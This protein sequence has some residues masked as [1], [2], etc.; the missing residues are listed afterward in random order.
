MAT[1][2][3]LVYV[4]FTKTFK[5]MAIVSYLA[6]YELSSCYHSIG[7]PPISNHQE[8]APLLGGKG[9]VAKD[10]RCRKAAFVWIRPIN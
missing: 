8:V 9:I 3:S 7:F 1:K 10:L 2:L 6:P 5:K 4:R